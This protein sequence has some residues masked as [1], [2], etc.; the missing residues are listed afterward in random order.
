MTSLRWSE[1]VVVVVFDGANLTSGKQK[2]CHAYRYIDQE[3]I[4][5]HLSVC[6]SVYWNF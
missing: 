6:L 2:Q 5:I 4:N 3:V 1:V